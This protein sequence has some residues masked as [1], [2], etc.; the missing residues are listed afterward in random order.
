MKS[1]PS[2]EIPTIT[3]PILGPLRVFTSAPSSCSVGHGNHLFDLDG[4][5]IKKLQQLIKCGHELHPKDSISKR[6]LGDFK[7][8]QKIIQL[9]KSKNG[10]MSLEEI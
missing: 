4:L 10:R 1:L 3:R 8:K 6:C 9:E 5:Q 7:R 2:Y